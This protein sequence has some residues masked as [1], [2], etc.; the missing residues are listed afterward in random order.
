[1]DQADV[2]ALVAFAE[3]IPADIREG[4]GVV[5]QTEGPDSPLDP[6]QMQ[7]MVQ[8]RQLTESPLIKGDVDALVVAIQDSNNAAE[9]D[10]HG[11]YREMLRLKLQIVEWAKRRLA[12]LVDRT[13]PA[14]RSTR[15]PTGCSRPSTSSSRA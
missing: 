8:V 2:V 13:A 15:R 12:N 10:R 14:R 5:L 1:M 6:D 3:Q 7:L 4:V 9:L 11:L